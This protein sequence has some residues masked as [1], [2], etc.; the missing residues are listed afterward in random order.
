MYIKKIRYIS[1]IC[2]EA[3]RGRI[4]MK[5][6]TGS[7]LADIINCVKFFDGRLRDFDSAMQWRNSQLYV[8][9]RPEVKGCKY[10]RPPDG[11]NYCLGPS[12]SVRR[13]R[14]LISI[15]QVA[16][17]TALLLLLLLLLLLVHAWFIDK[18]FSINQSINF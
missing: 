9:R 13:R 5:F 16:P 12:G 14:N 15:H 3:P 2:R 8:M 6:G 4:C 18:H 7:R 17:A 11:A 1:R 10:T